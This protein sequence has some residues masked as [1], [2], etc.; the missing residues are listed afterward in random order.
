MCELRIVVPDLPACVKRVLAMPFRRPP[1]RRGSARREWDRTTPIVLS[2]FREPPPSPPLARARVRRAPRR[3]P[4]RVGGRITLAS[5]NAADDDPASCH[6][7]LS[8]RGRRPEPA[9][10]GL[11][12]PP[13]AAHADPRPAPSTCSSPGR[14]AWSAL[15][16]SQAGGA[17]GVPAVAAGSLRAPLAEGRLGRPGGVSRG[18][19]ERSEAEGA[20]PPRCR[21]GGARSA[22]EGPEAPLSGASGA[23]PLFL[24]TWTL[25]PPRNGSRANFSGRR[26]D[27]RAWIEP[28][29]GLYGRAEGSP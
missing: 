10:H 29:S 13:G 28:R 18:G 12:Y 22:P 15:G 17:R 11:G 23:S 8:R 2:W 14:P 24:D 27:G 1:Y 16:S 7:G 25:S 3:R 19:A 4:G 26:D 6:D 20:K 9:H 5:P 21:G